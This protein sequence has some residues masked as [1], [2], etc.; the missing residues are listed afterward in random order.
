[1][2]ETIRTILK[3]IDEKVT[4]LPKD[5]SGEVND[6]NNG[7]HKIINESRKAMLTARDEI[8][9]ALLGIDYAE[10]EI[11]GQVLPGSVL[12]RIAVKFE[13]VTGLRVEWDLG[14]EHVNFGVLAPKGLGGS[15]SL[16]AATLTINE[17]G[18]IIASPAEADGLF[19]GDLLNDLREALRMARKDGW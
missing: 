14:K 8:N 4:D 12:N 5:A 11:D 18:Q 10:A 3:H 17:K 6:E 7:P 15:S 19:D 1:M 13:F 16:G 9:S 2:N